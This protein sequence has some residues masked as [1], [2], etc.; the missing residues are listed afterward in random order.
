M[1]RKFLA[2]FIFLLGLSGVTASCFAEEKIRVACVGDSITAGHLLADP[3]HTSYPAQLGKI[4]G[5]RYEVRNFGRS[6]ATLLKSGKADLSYW[7]AEQYAQALAFN[8]NIVIIMLGTNDTRPANW[9]RKADF[10][11]DC[12]ALTESFRLLAAKPEVYVCLPPPVYHQGAFKVTNEVL[13][14]V[15]SL[16]KEAA[17]SKKIT[18][19]DVN[20]ALAG[21]PEFFP[22]NVHPNLEGAKAIAETVAKT[23]QSDRAN[24]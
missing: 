13:E 10:V 17:A 7:K 14:Q 12:L 11:Q 22:D 4:L 5:E 9:V 6:G 2:F 3:E 18:L 8:P 16:M 15:L 1:E 20:T 23:L 24:P 21:H 19:I